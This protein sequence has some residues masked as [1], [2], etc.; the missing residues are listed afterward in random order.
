V[1]A[2]V[3]VGQSKVN[4]QCDLAGV[5]CDDTDTASKLYAGY[6]L[7]NFAAELGYADLGKATLTG[8]G[9]TDEIAATAWDLTALLGAPPSA[10]AASSTSP[11]IS[12]CARSGSATRR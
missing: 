5:T 1:Y 12:A 9:G 7:N 11:A 10:W 6:Q 4:I 2:G 3:N 8:P